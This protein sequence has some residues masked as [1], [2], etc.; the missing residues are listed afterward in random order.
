MVLYEVAIATVPK[1]VPWPGV[2]TFDGT[3][4]AHVVGP[5]GTVN[6]AAALESR[7]GKPISVSYDQHLTW[8]GG[9]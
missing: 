7:L 3:T 4:V 2:F 5:T 9:H 1:G 8:T 6:N